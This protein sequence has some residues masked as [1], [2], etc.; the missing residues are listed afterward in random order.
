MPCLIA[1][2]RDPLTDEPA[3]IQRIA[4][5][6]RDGRIEKI[7]RRMVGHAGVVKL[8]PP[9]AHLVVGEGLET[10][11]AAATRVT[12]R[13]NLL[14]PAWAV[15]SAGSLASFPVIPG[16]ERLIILVDHD[17]A[18][19]AAAGQ[20]TERWTRAGRTVIRLTPKRAGADFNDLVIEFGAGSMSGDRAFTEEISEPSPE[21]SGVTID[22]FVAYM[23]GHNYI[24]TPC[25]EPWPSASVNARLGRVPVLT[26]TGKPRLDKE[27]NPLTIAAS[28]W[29]DRNRAVE[30]MTWAP[31]MPE[32]IKGRLVVDG[33]WIERKDVTCFNLYRPPRLELGD[34]RKAG[35]WIKQV[36]RIYPDDADHV[37]KWLAHRVQR[38]GEKINH[39]LV[40]GG[41]QG[42]GKDSMLEPLKHAV[43]AW[44]FHDVS[45]THLLGRF[46]SFVKSV[47]LRVNEARDLGEV[48][49]FKFYDHTKIY[50]AAPPD[51]LRVDEK[52]LRE[53]YV[54]NVLGFIITTNH[55]TDGIYLPADDRR[56]YV[57]WSSWTKEAFAQEYWNRLWRWYLHEGGFGHVA[58]YLGE[59]DLSDFDPKAP[60]PKTPAF[61]DIV[62]AGSAP[63]SKTR[64]REALNK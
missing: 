54:F 35:P 48:D 10:V 62:A 13:D 49:R 20:C 39:A 31:G 7:D 19:I 30:Q 8:W 24:F 25:R 1:L 36:H 52:N 56:H 33:G 5:E 29:L 53:H 41:A 2:M 64:A 3:G 9:G 34:T 28:T 40:L 63:D 26:K 38:P 16:V 11:L 55:K 21:G 4:L 37:I 12:Y 42:I 27:G 58:S 47:I 44:N 23:P 61:W 46:N 15:M 43:G 60:P 45:P 59:L 18:G 32:Q 14:P 57:A 50:T 22:D 17:D 51:V 6:E